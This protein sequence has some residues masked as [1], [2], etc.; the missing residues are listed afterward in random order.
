MNLEGIVQ[1]GVGYCCCNLFMINFI[2]WDMFVCLI[3]INI[4]VFNKFYVMFFDE[5]WMLFLL[6]MFFFLCDV[7]DMIVQL[8]NKLVEFNKLK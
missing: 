3:R 8:L 1:K 7:W 6:R 4:Y 2:Y 5:D